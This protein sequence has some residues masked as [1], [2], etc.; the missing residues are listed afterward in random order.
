MPF[1]YLVIWAAVL[2]G[3][4]G[5]CSDPRV[6]LASSGATTPEPFDF[7]EASR[8]VPKPRE[9]WPLVRKHT[10][11]LQFSVRSDEIV[12]SDTDPSKRLRK[13]TAHFC[14]QELAGKKWGHPCVIFLPEDSD[15][16][17][18]PGRRGKEIPT[19]GPLS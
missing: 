8:G 17:R 3:A 5:I 12:T 19:P 14:S 7:G 1:R 6:C 15:R 4:L 18:T 9:I 13:V 2:S 11:P 10:V 16:N